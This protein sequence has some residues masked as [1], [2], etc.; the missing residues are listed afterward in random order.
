M[1]ITN[2]NYSEREVTAL[3]V[4]GNYLWIAFEG[5]GGSCHLYKTSVFNPNQIFYD[6]AVPVNKINRMKSDGT[7]IYLAV[8]SDDYICVSYKISN[9]LT[10]YIY[11]AKPE[12]IEEES[13]DLTVSD[14]YVY[15]LIPGVISGTYAKILQYSK[16]YLTINNTIELTKSAEEITNAR[17][18]DI[19]DGN[20]LWVATYTD[21]IKLIKVLDGVFTFESWLIT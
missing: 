13:I 18:I 10:S 3:L 16:T 17:T 2:Y 19:D 11:R 1:Q 9:P 6:I 8:D 5:S 7:Y 4:E 20:N 14:D 12:G 21:P 15:L